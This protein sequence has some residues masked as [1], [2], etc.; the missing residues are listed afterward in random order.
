MSSV[1]TEQKHVKGAVPVTSAKTGEVHSFNVLGTGADHASAGPANS[2]NADIRHILKRISNERAPDVLLTAFK[3]YWPGIQFMTM[4][5]AWLRV[6]YMEAIQGQAWASY[7]IADR[8]EGKVAESGGL[9][10]SK[11]A[12][13]DAIDKEMQNPVTEE[14]V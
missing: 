4:R 1:W 5:E 6:V 3:L 13:L 11:G 14:E 9:S 12:I 8:M 10:N 7:F 2:R